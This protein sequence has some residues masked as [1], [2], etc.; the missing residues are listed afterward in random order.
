M[1]EATTMSN[2]IKAAVQVRFTDIHIEGDN[3]ILI[4]AVKRKI[5]VPWEIQVL[6]QDISTFLDRFN[7][8]FI[9]YAFRQGNCIVDWLAKYELSIHSTTRWNLIPPRDLRHILIEDNL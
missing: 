1:A 8:V 5:Q 4:Q 9:N 6:V 7:N 3:R 2:G